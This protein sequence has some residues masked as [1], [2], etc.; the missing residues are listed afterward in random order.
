M[1]ILAIKG[2]VTRYKEVI[3]LLEMLG[4]KNREGYI[5]NN[6][7]ASYYISHKNIIKCDYVSNIYPN[8]Y[9]CVDYTLEEFLEKFPYKV[10]DKVQH[11]G[12]TSCGS[13]YEVEKMRWKENT[14]KYT[15]RLFGC[16]YKTS[17]LS[18][19]YLQPYKEETMGKAVFDA[20][21]QCCDIMNHLIK[22]ETMEENLTIQDIRDNNAEWLLNKLEGMSAKKA[23]QTIS[24]LY[25]KL[26]KPQYPK[27]YAE[28][29]D[30]LSISPY[31]NL[32]YHTYERCYN[33]YATADKLCSL[34][35]KLNILGKLLICRDAYWK[36]ASEQIGELWKPDWSRFE[37]KFT[38]IEWSGKVVK[39]E[40]KLHK[41]ILAFPTE[42]IRD[43]FY[44][45]FKDL[46][47]SCRE[48]L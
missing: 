11:K 45:N 3:E 47:E 10:G 28:C 42:E 9:K 22:K 14:V 1:S 12:A 7:K 31:Y 39:S 15:L 48:L 19:E 32:R 16:N 6:P 38:I 33:E 25:D 23:L 36:M 5:G 37:T 27:T 40:S 44:E 4:G 43:A 8:I 13:V 46:I 26:R 2:H 20:N 21:A 24:D 41:C 34:Q 30:V 35:D 17:T 18:A 29:C